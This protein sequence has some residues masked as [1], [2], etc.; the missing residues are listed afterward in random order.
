MYRVPL[1]VGAWPASPSYQRYLQSLYRS[2]HWRV[3]KL[4]QAWQQRKTALASRNIAIRH[5]D[6][7]RQ[8]VSALSRLRAAQHLAWKDIAAPPYACNAIIII[9]SAV[10]ISFALE[11]KIWHESRRR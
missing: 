5:Q 6:G 4:Q 10:A 7:G 2:A 11:K 9:S 3:S 1:R 8:N